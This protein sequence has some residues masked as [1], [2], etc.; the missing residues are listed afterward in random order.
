MSER[1]WGY[2]EKQSSAAICC[3]YLG[4]GISVKNQDIYSFI[5]CLSILLTHA[6][7]KVVLIYCTVV[8]IVCQT[9][10]QKCSPTVSGIHTVYWKFVY[11]RILWVHLQ[12]VQSKFNCLHI[13]C[14]CDN[15]IVLSIY[16]LEVKNVFL[17]WE[18]FL[19]PSHGGALRLAFLQV[20][21]LPSL[22]AWSPVNLT[23]S[24]LQAGLIILKSL[25]IKI[26]S[27][28]NLKFSICTGFY[29]VKASS[30][31]W[32]ELFCNLNALLQSQ[33]TDKPLL[34]SNITVVLKISKIK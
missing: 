30:S 23:V 18:F 13:N 32:A 34:T 16:L 4:T 24:W 6:K 21:H 15:L 2:L 7:M 11:V 10:V 33:N 20:T 8:Y 25:D 28:F 17:C 19:P 3:W 1:L 26:K 5:N 31:I 14:C 27:F 29:F 22:L 9:K 12:F